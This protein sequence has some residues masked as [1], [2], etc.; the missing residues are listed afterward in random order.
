MKIIYRVPQN[1]VAQPEV[2]FTVFSATVWN[3]NLKFQRYMYVLKYVNALVKCDSVEKR[4]NYRYFNMTAYPFFALKMFKL[5]LLFNFQKPDSS[6]IRT[7][8]QHIQSTELAAGQLS[9]FHHKRPVASTFAGSKPSG[10]SRVGAI[11]KAGYRKLKTKPK[12]ISELNETLRVNWGNLSLDR[13][14]RL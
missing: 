3:F 9:R 11:L 1:K 5:K 2:L 10:L 12:T 4:R 14:T 6:S 7:A 13:S 8:C